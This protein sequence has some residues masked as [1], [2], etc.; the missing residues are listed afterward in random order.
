MFPDLFY[1]YQIKTLFHIFCILSFQWTMIVLLEEMTKG[2]IN[3]FINFGKSWV[4][5]DFKLLERVAWGGGVTP[6]QYY[7]H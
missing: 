5:N 3:A 2:F 6:L 7:R 1:K 4:N